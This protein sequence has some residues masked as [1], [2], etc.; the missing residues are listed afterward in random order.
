MRKIDFRD[1][2]RGWEVKI[3]NFEQLGKEIK[4]GESEDRILEV[5]DFLAIKFWKL[6]A[7]GFLI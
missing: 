3:E 7:W 5:L 4:E 2:L 6:F 1:L